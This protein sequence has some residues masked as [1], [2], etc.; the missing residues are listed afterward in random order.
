MSTILADLSDTL[1]DPYYELYPGKKNEKVCFF[2]LQDPKCAELGEL[3]I[4]AVRISYLKDRQVVDFY[5]TR[6]GKEQLLDVCYDMMAL[7]ATR[8]REA[9][10]LTAAMK[11]LKPG[12][13]QIVTVEA[14]EIIGT[15]AGRIKVLPL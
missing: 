11:R 12:D 3:R 5:Y 9:R 7:P 15:E 4:T 14:S 13:S 1:L 6:D 10:G 2:F 8:D